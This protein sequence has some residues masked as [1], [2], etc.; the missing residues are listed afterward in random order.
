M[1]PLQLLVAAAAFFV[2]S[3]SSPASAE[4][5]VDARPALRELPSASPHVASVA[6]AC[7][8]PNEI[9]R[10][11]DTLEGVGVARVDRTSKLVSH[12]GLTDTERL[13]V[14]AASWAAASEPPRMPIF[15]ARM[16]QL[17]F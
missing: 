11:L 17:D 6:A 10:I 2:L 1:A 4:V 7:P 13:P 3:P 12:V 15:Y 8:L 5:Q 9:M 16:I 14:R